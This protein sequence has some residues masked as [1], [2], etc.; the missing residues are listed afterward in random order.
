MAAV[1]E[2]VEDFHGGRVTGMSLANEL[3]LNEQL[4][5]IGGED[6]LAKAEAKVAQVHAR[7]FA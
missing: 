6:M 5:E 4:V 1:L 7:A 3:T 2:P